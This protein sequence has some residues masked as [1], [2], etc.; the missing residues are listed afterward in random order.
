ME[1]STLA[2][3]AQITFDVTLVSADTLSTEATVTLK[4]DNEAAAWVATVA[5]TN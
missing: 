2:A 3:D 5:A 1:L 4:W